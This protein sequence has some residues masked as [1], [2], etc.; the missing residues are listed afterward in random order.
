MKQKSIKDSAPPHLRKALLAYRSL[1]AYSLNNYGWGDWKKII[2][3]LCDEEK[4]CPDKVLIILLSKH[5][6]WCADTAENSS[7]VYAKEFIEYYYKNKN[8]IQEMINNND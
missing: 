8:N 1:D 6:R 3:Y 4:L 7:Y 2:D 5:M